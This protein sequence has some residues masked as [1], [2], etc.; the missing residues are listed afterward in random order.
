MEFG[1]EKSSLPRIVHG[2]IFSLREVVQVGIRVL[3]QRE[4]EA[5]KSNTKTVRKKKILLDYYLWKREAEIP[6]L[7]SPKNW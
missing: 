3:Q 7:K 4:A 2:K 1:V 5:D 6:F